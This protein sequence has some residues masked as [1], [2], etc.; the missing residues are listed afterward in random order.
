[1]KYYIRTNLARIDKVVLVC[2]GRVQP[3]QVVS[4][5]QYL[6]WLGCGTNLD[7]VVVVYSKTDDFEP[8]EK[9]SSLVGIWSKLGF[10]RQSMEYTLQ[11]DVALPRTRV[12]KTSIGD[13]VSVVKR[14][15]CAGFRPGRSLKA[16]RGDLLQV[17]DT[18]FIRPAS[19][20]I[21]LDISSGCLIL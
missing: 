19:G 16:I 20:Q 5:K 2:D 17:T 14:A 6:D 1:M 4:M 3:A 7:N 11:R 21:K 8:S 10:S 18:S 13:Q 9:V 12:L 15:C